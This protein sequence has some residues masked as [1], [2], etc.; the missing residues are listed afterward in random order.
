MFPYIFIFFISL[1][2]FFVADQQKLR[3]GEH[4]RI[5]V[6][7][8]YIS[9]LIL[10]LFAG[11]RDLGVGTDTGIYSQSYF[12]ASRYIEN[13][14]DLSK[15]DNQDI[16]DKGYL[17]LNIV[18]SWFSD[19]IWLV[20]FLTELII[21][22]SLYFAVLSLSKTYK[23][24]IFVFSCFYLF[25][26]YNYT[27]NIMRQSC[28]VSLIFLSFSYF[29]RRKMIMSSFLFLLAYF[30]HSSSLIALILFLIYYFVNKGI[31]LP[32]W[33]LVGLLTGAIVLFMSFR[34]VTDLLVAWGMLSIQYVEVYSDGSI[35][36]GNS[37]ITYTALVLILMMSITI[38]LSIKNKILSKKDNLFLLIIHIF[39]IVGMSFG[40]IIS[41]LARVSYIFYLID[42]WMLSVI[43]SSSQIKRSYKIVYFLILAFAWWYSI[44]RNNEGETFPYKSEI[45]GI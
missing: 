6:I 31:K 41:H 44:I 30:F 5:S 34:D 37:R 14:G 20:L 35:Y 28:A 22:S 40:L 21:L 3:S 23:L 2:L 29:V 45:L 32:K 10:S 36:D 38:Y 1:L 27:F 18:C 17:V 13:W 39:Y 8:I 26:F 16:R 43:L 42:I 7:I 33:I 12:N 11:V 25:T 24:S 19:N 9:I 4:S 15:F